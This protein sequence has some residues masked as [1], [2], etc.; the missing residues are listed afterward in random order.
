MKSKHIL[1]G[2]LSLVII[3]AVI[4]NPKKENHLD[5]VFNEFIV[6]KNELA[7]TNGF[8]LMALPFA[9]NAFGEILS[10]DNYVLFSIGKIKFN[11]INEK[12]SIGAFGNVFLTINKSEWDNLGGIKNEDNKNADNSKTEK[13]SL[14]DENL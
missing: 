5:K 3:T 14:K 13:L 9:K 8:E 12:I 11:G 10:V 4:T 6:N 7:R 2:L 1:L